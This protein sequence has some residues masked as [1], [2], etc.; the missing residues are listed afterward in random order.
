MKR[1]T[2]IVP[3][4]NHKNIEQV[5][6]EYELRSQ[7]YGYEAIRA[8]VIAEGF[9]DP[10]RKTNYSKNSIEKRLKNPFYYGNFRWQGREYKGKHELII[11]QEL[12]KAVQRTYISRGKRIN[13]KQG[14]VPTGWLRCHTR[15]CNCQICYDPKIKILKTTKEKRL[16][17]YYRCSNLRGIH[18]SMRGM[19]LKEEVLWGEL[20]KPVTDISIEKPFGDSIYKE[21]EALHEKHRIAKKAEIAEFKV[22]LKELEGSEDKL[23][24]SFIQGVLDEHGYRRQIQR[25]REQRVHYT[26]LLESANDE[27]DGAY[28]KSAKILLELATTAKSQWNSSSSTERILLLKK[29]CSDPQLDGQR[30]RYSLRN[31]LRIIAD[32]SADKDWRPQGDSNPCILREREVS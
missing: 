11:N 24:D 15:E 20:E 30:L 27:I 26:D 32:M 9:I 23:Y 5:R 28:L 13:Q 25:V 31:P 16:F 10:K 14:S 18:K 7:G 29:I 22:A 3:D 19:Y 21:L 2:I 17:A 8:E 12:L 6:R 4:P 1:G